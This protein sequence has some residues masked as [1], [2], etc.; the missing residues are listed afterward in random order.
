MNVQLQQAIGPIKILFSKSDQRR[1]DHFLLLQK[2]G[3]FK[4]DCQKLK[5]DQEYDK[6]K[7]E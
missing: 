7:K 3:H 1:N 4:Q 5:W 6:L 2:I